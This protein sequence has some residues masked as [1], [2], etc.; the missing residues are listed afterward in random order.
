MSCCCSFDRDF[1]CAGFFVCL[2][3]FL[4]NIVILKLNNY[5]EKYKLRDE[6][7]TMTF[8]EVFR[9]MIWSKSPFDFFDQLS[10]FHRH[11]RQA[12]A[13]ISTFFNDRAEINKRNRSFV[14]TKTAP[15]LICLS[16]PAHLIL[17]TL[18]I[19]TYVLANVDIYI[20]F[21]SIR[22]YPFIDKRTYYRMISSKCTRDISH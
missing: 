5:L 16:H 6:I 17:S 13:E 14:Q 12:G 8:S 1:Y 7:L 9:S 22:N 4:F 2:N 19:F 18:G 10:N 21:I 11:L 3:A 20:G 15:S